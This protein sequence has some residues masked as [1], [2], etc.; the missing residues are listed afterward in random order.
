MEIFICTVFLFVLLIYGSLWHFFLIICFNHLLNK[1]ASVVTYDVV[2][3]EKSHL[4]S[5][6]VTHMVLSN[7]VKCVSYHIQ[8]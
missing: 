2:V 5:E 6:K 8:W 7:L 4:S 3:A 1:S